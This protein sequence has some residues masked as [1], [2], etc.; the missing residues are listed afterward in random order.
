MPPNR[1]IPFT[2]TA[3][4]R[5]AHPGAIVAMLHL[6]GVTNEDAD[7]RL[8]A[9]LESTAA[10]LRARHAGASR[11]S[12]LA[13]PDLAAYAAYYRRFG[14]TYHVLLQLESVVLKDRPIRARGTL[15]GAMFAA[16]L[17]TGLL[18]AGHDADAV[19]GGIVVD[20]MGPGERYVTLGGREVEA[21]PGDMA[22]RDERGIV[23]SIVYGPDDRTKL[24]RGTRSVASTVYGPVGVSRAAVDTHLDLLEEHVRAVDP[25]AIA[26]ARVVLEAR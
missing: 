6:A 4:W 2:A 24:G 20:V 7:P 14:K 23:S 3:G 26:E 5:A 11:Q 16:E 21:A 13:G 9:V 15:V 18:T 10:D 8:D 1:A 19:A 22:M 12:L 25:G 17:R